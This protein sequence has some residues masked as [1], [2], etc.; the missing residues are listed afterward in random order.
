MEALVAVMEE[1]I[2]EAWKLEATPFQEGDID[3]ITCRANPAPQIVVYREGSVVGKRM[4]G[5]T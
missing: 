5:S 1:P 3:E 4:G 2:L